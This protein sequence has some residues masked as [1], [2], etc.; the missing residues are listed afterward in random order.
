MPPVGP[1]LPHA[2]PDHFAVLARR[3][4]ETR[5]GVEVANL[6]P[7]R[8]ATCGDLTAAFGFSELPR[9]DLPSLPDT[10]SALARAEDEAMTLPP[11]V[12]PTAETPPARKPD[13]RLRCGNA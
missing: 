3:V 5:W 12:P 2:L 13:T 11:P 9:L 1:W 7:W 8:R 4:I 10:R 6:S